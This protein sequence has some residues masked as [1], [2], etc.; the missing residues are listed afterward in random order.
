MS[1]SYPL[2]DQAL[3]ERTVGTPNMGYLTNLPTEAAEGKSVA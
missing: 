3:I 2:R 1:E